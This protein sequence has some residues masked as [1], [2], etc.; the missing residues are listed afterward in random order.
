M[1]KLLTILVL[2]VMVTA[3]KSGKEDQKTEKKEVV[4]SAYDSFGE[5]ITDKDF[6]SS[7]DVMST[8]KNLKEGDTLNIKFASKINEVCTNKGCWMKLPAGEGEETVMVRFKD[9]AFFMP[10]DSQGREVIVSE[11]I[12]KVDD[13]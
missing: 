5:K 3:C 12:V 2:A 13:Y 9:Y 4:A 8:Y 10:T 11:K 1:R 6:L 7:V